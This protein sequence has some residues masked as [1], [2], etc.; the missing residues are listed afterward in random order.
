[1]LHN[2]TA[3]Y[4]NGIQSMVLYTCIRPYFGINWF[5]LTLQALIVPV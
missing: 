4:E 5:A 2:T 3:P 1:M